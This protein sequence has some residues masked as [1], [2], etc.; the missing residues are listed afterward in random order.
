MTN[1]KQEHDKKVKEGLDFMLD[2]YGGVLDK[3]AEYDRDNTPFKH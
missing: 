2:R 1:E 3:L